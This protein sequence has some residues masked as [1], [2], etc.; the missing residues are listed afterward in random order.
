MMANPLLFSAPFFVA[1]G[2]KIAYDLMLHK[3]F[4]DTE[5]QAP[6]P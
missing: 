4:K 3:M 6:S 5:E 2:L 1:G